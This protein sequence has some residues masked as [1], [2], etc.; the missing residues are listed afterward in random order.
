MSAEEDGR[1]EFFRHSVGEEEIRAV[2]EA[3]RGPFLT[4]GKLVE[5][6]EKELAEYLEC[7]PLALGVSSC[8]AALHLALLALEVSQGDEVITTPMT[9]IATANVILHCGATPVFVDVEPA[10]G[11]IDLTAVEAAI[12]PRTKAVIAVH[13]YGQMADVVR[14]RAT[15]DARGI[16]LIED[17]AHATDAIRDGVRPGQLGDAAAFSFYATK[18]ITSGEG[19]A[20]VMRDPARFERARMLHQHGMSASAAD[21]HSGA[22]RHWD[23][24]ALGYKYN[25][26]NLQA[27]MLR[28]QLHRIDALRAARERLASR[29]ED[30]LTGLSGIEFPRSVPAATSARHLFTMWAPDG[31]R[32]AYLAG[33]NARGI[34]TAVNYRAVHLLTYYR[35]R[36]GF[37]RGAY[38]VAEAIGD[39]TLSLPLFPSMT[40][41]EQDRVIEAVRDVHRVG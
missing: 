5:A 8:T 16:A 24:L 25:M 28:P 37:D 14:L 41:E 2:A 36:F 34:G 18:N 4:R 20:L 9:F 26:T 1:V 12:S 7:K 40:L 3:M 32:D 33:L 15:C 30:A 39:R 19:G 6:F 31:R 10:T 11:L 13:L 29:Y 22:Y 23:M 38:P 21:R 27:A 17:A 35:E